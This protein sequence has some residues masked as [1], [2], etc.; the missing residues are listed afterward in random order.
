MVQW[1]RPVMSTAGGHG[2]D[3]WMG[4]KDPASHMDPA[5]HTLYLWPQKE[6]DHL[7]MKKEK[8]GKLQAEKRFIFLKSYKIYIAG[9]SP[10][11]KLK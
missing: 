5:S 7:M 8:M 3:P 6:K 2:F 1:L 4:N 11:A 9:K 10:M